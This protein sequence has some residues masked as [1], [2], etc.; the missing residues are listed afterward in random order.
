MSL[1]NSSLQLKQSALLALIDILRRQAYP[2][3]LALN[4]PGVAQALAPPQYNCL[5]ISPRS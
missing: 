4:P 2:F 1:Y 5:E 3:E